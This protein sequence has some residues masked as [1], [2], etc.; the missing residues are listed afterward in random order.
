MSVQKIIRYFYSNCF[1]LFIPVMLLNITLT[2]YLPAPYLKSISHVA[3][4]VESAVRIALIVFSMVMKISVKNRI[5]KI[6]VAVYL[7]GIIVYFFSYF[8]LIN[9]TN[10]A[11][12]NL[13]LQLSGYWTAAIWLI[14][15]GL[16]GNRLFVKI[17]Y[18]YVAYIILSAAFGILH[19]YHG[20]ILL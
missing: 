5:G 15:I 6:G 4:P 12:E 14:G 19:T 17:P 16:M 11:G 3:I 7:T 10:I 9:H 13:M 8:L 1:L 18:H 20:Y 2:P